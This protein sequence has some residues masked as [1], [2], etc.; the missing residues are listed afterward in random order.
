MSSDRQVKAG[1]I[2]LLDLEPTRG[3]EQ[4][5]VRPVLVISADDLHRKSRRM[6]VCPITS[7]LKPWTTKVPLPDD[8]RTTGMVLT[9]QIRAV[10][11]KA[12]ILR[13]IETVPPEFVTV[14]RS[15][16]GRLLDLELRQ[17]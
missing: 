1:D 2:F 16:V 11:M 3:S 9:D 4:A 10:D 14:V 8:C 6:I 15:Y 7:N 17:F 13:H 5:G 12:R